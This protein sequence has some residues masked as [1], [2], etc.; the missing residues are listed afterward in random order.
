MSDADQL[1]NEEFLK[2]VGAYVDGE[3]PAEE[4]EAV[5]NQLRTNPNHHEVASTYRW[6]DEI[7]NRD[8]VPKVTGK[9]WTQVWDSIHERKG[10][11]LSDDSL[12]SV[13]E[14]EVQEAKIVRP[15]F[16][17][18]WVGVAAAILLAA[19][20]LLLF[21]YNTQPQMVDNRDEDRPPPVA[22]KIEDSPEVE[23]IEGPKPEIDKDEG[24]IRY[25]DF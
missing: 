22:E 25:K 12:D 16:G 15:Q 9:E 10:Q 21:L 11:E 7:A 24:I 1:G 8:T 14:G 3:L 5:E 23:V 17:S 13:D 19:C 4:R 2:K 18:V 6:L 20:G